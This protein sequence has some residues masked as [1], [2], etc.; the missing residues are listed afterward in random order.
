MGVHA[1]TYTTSPTAALRLA[2]QRQREG[3]TKLLTTGSEVID[4][5]R[6]GNRSGGGG[7]GGGVSRAKVMQGVYAAEAGGYAGGARVC[8]RVHVR[9]VLFF[10]FRIHLAL[11]PFLKNHAHHT[12]HIHLDRLLV[13]AYIPWHHIMLAEMKELLDLEMG[14]EGGEGSGGGL[15]LSPPPASLGRR[16]TGVQD[17][18]ARP[19]PAARAAAANTNTNTNISFR[20]DTYRDLRM[21]QSQSQPSSY[22]LARSGSGGGMTGGGGSAA[23]TAVRRQRQR[24]RAG[25]NNSTRTRPRGKPG[26]Q[27]SAATAIATATHANSPLKAYVSAGAQRARSNAELLGRWGR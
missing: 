21:R 11:M 14:S 7:N 1:V 6:R 25:G 8:V 23:R 24:Q 19:R 9:H 18:V 26:Q 12:R 5:H 22:P 4:T 10:C 20:G 2:R 27:Q 16:F 3:Q 17:V 15:A 13:Y